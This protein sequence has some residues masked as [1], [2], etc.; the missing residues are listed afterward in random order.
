MGAVCRT[1]FAIKTTPE[2]YS[3]PLPMQDGLP[4]RLTPARM[5]IPKVDNNADG[6]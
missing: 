2:C 5:T 1:H 6:C 3:N 4:P